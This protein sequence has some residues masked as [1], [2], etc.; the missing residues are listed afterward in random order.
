MTPDDQRLEMADLVRRRQQGRAR[1]LALLLIALV[2]LIF[3]VTM[4]KI[5]AGTM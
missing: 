5:R 3:A 1:V 4:V 2:V